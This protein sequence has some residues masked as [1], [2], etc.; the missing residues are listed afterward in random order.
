VRRSRLPRVG[1]RFIA[2]WLIAGALG[3]VL[4]YMFH[5]GWTSLLAVVGGG[6]S[7]YLVIDEISRRRSSVN[8][9]EQLKEISGRL[10]GAVRGQWELEW[11]AREFNARR[12]MPVS[13]TAVDEDLV[14]SWEVVGA[15]RPTG[16]SHADDPTAPTRRTRLRS[17]D[18]SSVEDLRQAFSRVPTGR[19]LILGEPG[20]GKSV[21]L[22]HFVLESARKRTTDDTPIPVFLSLAS[23]TPKVAAAPT[24]DD[25]LETF[26][27]FDDDDD[28]DVAEEPESRPQSEVAVEAG[29]TH[30]SQGSGAPGAVDRP[31]ITGPN[32]TAQSFTD[33]LEAALITSYP[34]L[35]GEFPG[36]DGGEITLARALLNE[37]RLLL[38]LDGL[39]EISPNL[40]G[41]ALAEIN[42]RDPADKMVVAC[43]V[44]AY[45]TIEYGSQR[46]TLRNAACLRLNNLELG[47]VRSYLCP[48]NDEE[49]AKRWAPVLAAQN[50]DPVVSAVLATPLMVDLARAIYNPEPGRAGSPRNPAELLSRRKLPDQERVRAHL[51][52]SF[53]DT[54]YR[55]H[56]PTERRRWRGDHARRWLSYLARNLKQ[57]TSGGTEN[58]G[59]A[60]EWWDLPLPGV[61]FKVGLVV[62]GLAA[63]AIGLAAGFGSHVGTGF[64][65]GLGA[66]IVLSV[67]IG[68]PIYGLR[69]VHDRPLVGL[70]AGLAGGF[71][72]GLA[73]GIASHYGF[74]HAAG[75]AGGI[76]AGLGVGV[77]SGPVSGRVG[78]FFGP[79]FGGFLAG[80]VAGVG[81]GLPAGISNGIGSGLGAGLIAGLARRPLP[82]QRVHWKPVGAV[83]G[84][85]A[86]TAVA[87]VAV[88]AGAGL[89]IGLVAGA[90][91]A[92]LAALASGLDGVEVPLGESNN[93]A[94]VLHRDRASFALTGLLAGLAVGLVTAI[95]VALAAAREDNTTLTVRFLIDNGLGTGVAVGFVCG[96]VL[97]FV[98]TAWGWFAVARCWLAAQ[99]RL[100]WRLMAFLSDAHSQRGILIHDGPTYRFR[101][102]EIAQYLARRRDKR[103]GS[104]PPKAPKQRG[105]EA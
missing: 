47:D 62:G 88:W 21:L 43:R 66:G 100:P 32:S 14:D 65:F 92:L 105:A 79:M 60:L 44:E 24:L 49:A 90:V 45:R 93:P 64:G 8:T 101:H 6:P 94:A 103:T 7:T 18:G 85:A 76:A 57:S 9:A 71:I 97:S 5:L 67:L 55:T 31:R 50:V 96:L 25:D 28:D 86:G 36:N 40:R 10:V 52:K 2:V 78:G 53:I 69:R 84:L 77:A 23:W 87:L 15:T 102:D 91:T 16:T 4:S 11:E 3:V 75:P 54:A 48:K 63:I 20:A 83:G 68:L 58:N 61:R 99:G 27:D 38:V 59:G 72:G 51:F 30:V 34:E 19:L 26:D 80:L 41:A 12:L 73:A 37:H 82:A 39:D 17:L 104:P 22:Q 13:W 56:G 74:G 42:N 35:R 81:T 95:L 46:V 70:G 29:A 33:W 98:Q 89:G 1:W